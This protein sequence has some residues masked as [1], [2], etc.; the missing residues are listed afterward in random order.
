MRHHRLFSTCAFAIVAA[1]LYAPQAA[2]AACT[3]T[4]FIRDS[5]DL[6]AAMINPSGV[7][8]GDVDA[9][10]CNIGIYYSGGHGRVNQA[11]VHGANYFGIVNNGGDVDVLNSTVSEIGETPFNGSQHG[12]GIDFEGA[13]RGDIKGNFVSDYQKNGIVVKGPSARADIQQNYVVGLGA[14]NFIAQNGIEAGLGARARIRLNFV[15]GFSYTGAN[16]ASSSGIIL[17]GGAYY[18]GALQANTEISNNVVLNSDIGIALAN[19]DAGGA[20]PAAATRNFVANNRLVNNAI[21]NTTGNGPTQG[22]QAGVLDTGNGDVI[23]NNDICGLGYTPPGTAAVAIFDID[24]SFT[25]N[26]SIVHNTTC[27][28][29]RRHHD[30]DHGHGHGHPHFHRDHH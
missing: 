6:T 4:G 23:R 26:P 21:T 30:W 29:P 19:Y 18:G 20:I 9:T 11:N 7:V 10:G 25:S 12:V 27:A 3:A 15:S 5:I 16:Q 1:A 28:G 22:Y 14:V 13:A 8:S 2:E 24:D 17:F